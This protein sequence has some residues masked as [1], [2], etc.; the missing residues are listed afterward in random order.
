MTGR[1]QAKFNKECGVDIGLCR[2]K[3]VRDCDYKRNCQDD[4]HL[5]SQILHRGSVRYGTA[6][7]HGSASSESIVRTAV[8]IGQGRYEQ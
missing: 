4:D 5:I 2:T 1:K 3:P 7:I 8:D 6:P